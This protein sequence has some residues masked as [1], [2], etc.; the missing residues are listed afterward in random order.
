[1]HRGTCTMH[2]MSTQ[3]RRVVYF[4]DEEWEDARHRATNLDMTIS[5]YIRSSV[6]GGQV[7]PVRVQQA[8]LTSMA[9][10]LTQADRDAILRRVNK[11]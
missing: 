10:T 3:K 1:M 9:A 2:R 4:T 5:A 11:G 8:A 7:I 6:I